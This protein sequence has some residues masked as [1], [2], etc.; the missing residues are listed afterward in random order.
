[1][2]GLETETLHHK[3]GVRAGNTGGIHLREVRVPASHLLGE[4]GERFKIAMSALDNGRLTVAAG[5][6][7][8]ARV[9]LEESVRYAKERETFGKPIAEHQLVQQMMA[10][11]AEGYESSRLLYSWAV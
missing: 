7:G 11:I 1:M 4:E 2:P 3:L 10:R 6:T 8:T 5:V 9:C